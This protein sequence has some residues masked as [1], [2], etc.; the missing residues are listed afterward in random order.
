MCFYKRRNSNF[1]H[2]LRVVD[3]NYT[4]IDCGCDGKEKSGRKQMLNYCVY[5]LFANRIVSGA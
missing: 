4:L 3:W 1:H 5:P 2:S